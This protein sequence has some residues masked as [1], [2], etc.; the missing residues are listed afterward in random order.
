MIPIVSN[1][2]VS[3]YSHVHTPHVLQQHTP[4]VS[5]SIVLVCWQFN[6]F[7]YVFVWLVR[8]DRAKESASEHC[9]LI[10]HHHI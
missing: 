9:T 2:M 5:F 8:C 10:G 4:H 7:V 3:V 6:D 1:T